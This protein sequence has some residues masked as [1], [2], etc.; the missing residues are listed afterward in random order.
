MMF[1]NKIEY[2]L[3]QEDRQK[4]SAEVLKVD[5]SETDDILDQVPNKLKR[6]LSTV[7]LHPFQVDLLSD[8]SR[9]YTVLSESSNLDEDLRKWILFGLKYFV[10][11]KGDIPDH[12]PD[13]GYLDDAVVVRWVIDQTMLTYPDHF[14]G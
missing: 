10:D 1:N 13:I 8:V 11:S 12:V 4:Y 9:L 3:T 2:K 6:M 7:G 14:D 5:L